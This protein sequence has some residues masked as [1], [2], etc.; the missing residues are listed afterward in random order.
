MGAAI[1][2]KLLLRNSTS[3]LLSFAMALVFTLEVSAV[4]W[5]LPQGTPVRMRINRTVSSEDVHQGE[6]VDFETLDDVKL[7][8]LIIIPK[9]SMALATITEAVAKRR[10]ARGGKLNMNIDFVRL[11]TGEKLALRGVSDSSGGGHSG[12]MTGGMIATS[13]VFIPAAP[14]F[15]FIHGKDVLIPKGHEITVYTNSDY[16]VTPAKFSV[17]S[18]TP[19]LET[20][21]ATKSGGTLLTNADIIKLKDAGFGE[22]L[23]ID[24]IKNSS[25]DYRLDTDDL[26]A[27][28]KAGISD[29]VMSAMMQA[30][31]K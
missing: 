12:G 7:N 3:A 20:R 23:I 28:K 9:G 2:M 30:G 14:L 31:K 26:L 25:G 11:P 29:T 16:L 27:L 10:M 22:Q 13:I 24:K 6:N 8:D 19:P 15:L 1:L 21:A 5:N 4:D 17:T 18:Q